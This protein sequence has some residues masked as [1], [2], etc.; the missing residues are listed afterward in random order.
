MSALP[1]KKYTVILN[2]E[3]MIVNQLLILKLIY[4]KH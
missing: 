2:S 1:I 4:P 3:G